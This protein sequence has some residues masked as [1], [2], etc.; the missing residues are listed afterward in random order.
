[1]HACVCVCVCVLTGALQSREMT[2]YCR[3]VGL[4][5]CVRVCVCVRAPH[6]RLL[7][8]SDST[9]YASATSLNLSSLAFFSDSGTC[10]THTHTQTRMGT[11]KC[12]V[13]NMHLGVSPTLT[14]EA[15]TRQ[16]SAW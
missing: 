15:P 2:K 6:L 7:S 9:S 5:V 1:M 10:D 13:S 16:L 4:C 14:R 11:H 12:T 8:W 3:L